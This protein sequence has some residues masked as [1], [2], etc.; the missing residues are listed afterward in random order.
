[1]FR[2]CCLSSACLLFSLLSPIFDLDS[3]NF[4]FDFCVFCRA[5][6]VGD[7]TP[8]DSISIQLILYPLFSRFTGVCGFDH[9]LNRAPTQ[10]A[11][12]ARR[13]ISNLPLYSHIQ[14]C[15]V[16]RIGQKSCP[17]LDRISRGCGFARN[18]NRRFVLFEPREHAF[19][20]YASSLRN[21]RS[22]ELP[23]SPSYL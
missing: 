9:I 14:Y 13:S 6:R 12:T 23:A 22:R 5:V 11:K 10:P 1:M 20:L 7:L 2:F 8:P 19:A 15:P 16:T 4:G 18:G 3:S 21:A 17:R